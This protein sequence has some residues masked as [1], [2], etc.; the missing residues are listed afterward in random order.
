M[1]YQSNPPAL[2]RLLL[3]VAACPCSP[4]VEPE[5]TEV[6]WQAGG[7]RSSKSAGGVAAT[8][9]SNRKSEASCGRWAGLG[10]ESGLGPD[11]GPIAARICWGRKVF[12]SL[13]FFHIYILFPHYFFNLYLILKNEVFIQPTF[14]ILKMLTRLVCYVWCPSYPL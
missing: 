13:F 9:D 7:C 14:H 5:S 10:S 11:F 8:A 2:F 6:A 4:S 1:V 3:T 12:L